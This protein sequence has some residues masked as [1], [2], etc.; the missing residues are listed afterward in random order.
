MKILVICLNEHNV[1]QALLVHWNDTYACMTNHHSLE[2]MAVL[3]GDLH[4]RVKDYFTFVMV[5]VTLCIFR[6]IQ[7]RIKLVP[8]AVV[9][10]DS[11]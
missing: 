9:S 7:S 5:S 3:V 2:A 4:P 8:L 1:H 6:A 10:L 11:R